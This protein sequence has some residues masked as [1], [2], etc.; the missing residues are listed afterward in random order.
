MNNT[1]KFDC[2]A[3]SLQATSKI[4]DDFQDKSDLLNAIEILRNFFQSS[5]TF[6]EHQLLG[7]E[8]KINDAKNVVMSWVRYEYNSADKDLDYWQM[9]PEVAQFVLPI[10]VKGLALGDLRKLL[11]FNECDS[12]DELMLKFSVPQVL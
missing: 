8:S 11:A 5:D 12:V 7:I 6:S 1:A 10:M 2:S 3:N 4:S 9:S